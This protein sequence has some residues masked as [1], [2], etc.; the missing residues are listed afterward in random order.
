MAGSR[1]EDEALGEFELIERY[2]ARQSDADGVLIGIGDDAAVIDAEGPVA[3]AIDTLVAGTHF[4]ADFPASSVGYR[5]LAVNLSDLAAMGAT[6]RW[7]MLALTLP[8]ADRAWLEGFSNGLFELANR[9]DVKLVGGDLT[10]GP[11]AATV[12]IIG[13]V[14]PGAVLTRGAGRIGDDV[15]VTGTLG[16]ATA[17]LASLR[18]PRV[19]DDAVRA[20]LEDRFGRPDV[21]IAEGLA[22]ATLA[23]AA[24]DV[25]DGLIADL[26]HI[27]VQSA[28]AAVV[29]VDLIPLSAELRAACTPDLA[30]AH[31]LGGGDDYELC[32]TASPDRSDAIR[33][34]MMQVGTRVT[35]I[36]KL[37]V[38]DSV[39]CRRDGEP[40][41]VPASGYTHF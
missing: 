25:S 12:Q 41:S 35:R 38:G 8:D 9:H 15:Y 6:P 3:V 1:N 33:S 5:V 18:G 22:I 21:R 28:C 2:F 34:A 14:T 37:I 7:A 20:R 4:P 39:V 32:F 24:I 40:F 10:R 17:G 27:C 29:D 36:G 19:P 16:D 11:L 30:L 23:N 31:A 13:T 26:G